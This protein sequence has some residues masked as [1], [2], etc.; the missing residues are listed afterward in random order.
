VDKMKCDVLKERYKGKRAENYDTVRGGQEKWRK[1]N[2]IVGNFLSKISDDVNS[3][4]DVPVGTGRFFSC[5]KEL[6]FEVF[7]LDVSED[8][9]E[10]ASKKADVLDMDVNLLE[11]DVVSEALMVNVDLIVCTRFLN[12]IN[13]NDF[14]K[15]LRNF[16]SANPKYLILEVAHRPKDKLHKKKTYR[17]LESE[18]FGVFD[19]LNLNIIECQNTIDQWLNIY[20]MEMNDE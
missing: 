17:Y 19:K 5:Y 12:W 16:C 6:G 1:E 18:V 2:V 9:L 10:Q 7:G 14:E 4:L 11:G 13:I 3:V 8:M 15:V 20:L